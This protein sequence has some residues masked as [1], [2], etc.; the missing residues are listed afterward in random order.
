MKVLVAGG[1]GFIGRALCEV[2]DGRGHGVTAFARSEPS[3]PLPG[4]VTVHTGNVSNRDEVDQ[5]IDGHEVVYNLVALSPLFKPP[6]GTSH[7]KVHQHGTEVLVRAAESAA[8]DRFVQLSALGADPDGPTAY[9]RTKGRAE[10]IVTESDLDWT[11]MRP[12]VVFG[13]GGEFIE[14]SKWV[15]FPPMTDGLWWPYVSPLPGAHSRFQPIWRED[16]VEILADVIKDPDHIGESYELGGPSQ[17]TLAEIV[18]LIHRAEGKPARL[19][20]MPTALAKAALSVGGMIPGFPLGGDQGRS[21]DLD[22]VPVENQLSAFGRTSDE[23]RTLQSY[24]G[25]E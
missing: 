13:E 12:S 24:F 7:T 2:L 1:T 18:R 15:A 10:E 25:I 8:V 5:A 6:R 11:I 20:P 22:N 14:F 9:L 19:I 3:S 16:F 4:D 17:F 21:L 23:L